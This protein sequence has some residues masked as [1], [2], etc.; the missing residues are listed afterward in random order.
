MIRGPNGSHNVACDN[1]RG[2]NERRRM[3]V[4][5]AYAGANFAVAAKGR[6]MVDRGEYADED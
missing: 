4:G 2:G 5:R 6:T 1:L 3:A